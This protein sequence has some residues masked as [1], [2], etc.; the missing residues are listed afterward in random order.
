[1]GINIS[2]YYQDRK[3]LVLWKQF[4]KKYNTDQ[5]LLGSCLYIFETIKILKFGTSTKNEILKGI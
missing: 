5:R 3:L 4:Y 2:G 1:M